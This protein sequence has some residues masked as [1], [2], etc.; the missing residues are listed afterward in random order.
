MKMK[1]LTFGERVSAKITN[2]KT[3]QNNELSF[4]NYA[5]EFHIILF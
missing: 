4:N 5:L 1:A 2:S 3:F